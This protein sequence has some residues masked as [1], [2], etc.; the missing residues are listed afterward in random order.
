MPLSVNSHSRSY[1]YMYMY[2]IMIAN[3]LCVCV[4]V[5]TGQAWSAWS[6]WRTWRSGEW[7]V[8]AE[9]L[10]YKLLIYFNSPIPLPLFARRVTMERQGAKVHPEMLVFRG[11]RGPRV[12]LAYLVRMATTESRECLDCQVMMEYLEA[13]Y[14]RLDYC[15]APHDFVICYSLPASTIDDS[16]V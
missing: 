3:P 5:C 12:C 15:T 13:R 4:C 6:K 14:D 8:V 16:N 10:F 7:A 1:M 9:S 11:H 2:A